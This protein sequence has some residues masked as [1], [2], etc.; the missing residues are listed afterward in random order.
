MKPELEGR[1]LRNYKGGKCSTD[2]EEYRDMFFMAGKHIRVIIEVLQDQGTGS[3]GIV[4][5]CCV[6]DAP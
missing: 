4:R 1:F 3:I 2:E 6:T 5:K